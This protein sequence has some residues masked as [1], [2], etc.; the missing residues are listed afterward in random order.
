MLV[1]MAVFDAYGAGFE[2]VDPKIIEAHNHLRS[3]LRHPKWKG[4]P[5]RYTDDTQMALALAELLLRKPPAT[6]T[7][8]DV[9]RAF[10]GVFK[11][12][13]RPGYSGMFYKLLQQMTSGWDFLKMVRPFSDKSGG[14]MRAPVIGLLPN[15]S[16]VVQVARFQASLTHCTQ[17]GMDAAVASALMTH[18]FYYRLGPKHELPLFLAEHGLCFGIHRWQGHVSSQGHEHVLAAM[19]AILDNDTLEDVLK[20]C[21]DFTGDVDTIAAIAGPAASFCDEIEQTL[22]A[23]LLDNLEDGKFGRDYLD[24]IDDKLMSK[25]PRPGKAGEGVSE[26]GDEEAEDGPPHYHCT[27]CGQPVVFEVGDEPA[28]EFSN[29]PLCGGIDSVSVVVEPDPLISELFSS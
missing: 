8:Y 12:D 26:D 25:F 10:V 7:H 11:R 28:T 9:A 16:E 27:D 3:Y 29:C 1:E 21:V 23:V 20:A 4:P 13:P 24:G 15:V 18:Y 19:T 22:P 5:G 6:W 2:Y 17:L 14:A